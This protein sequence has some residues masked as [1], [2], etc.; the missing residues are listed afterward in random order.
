[1]KTSAF[2]RMGLAMPNP[3]EAARPDASQ[4]NVSF[5]QLSAGSSIEDTS[6]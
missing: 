6:D 5:R 3:S 1:M 4:M 2:A